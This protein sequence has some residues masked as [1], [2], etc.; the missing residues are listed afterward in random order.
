MPGRINENFK[1]HT[2]RWVLVKRTEGSYAFNLK[3]SLSSLSFLLQSKIS[4]CGTTYDYFVCRV[5]VVGIL[6]V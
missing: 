3:V 5:F 2:A 1:M 6:F 4:L